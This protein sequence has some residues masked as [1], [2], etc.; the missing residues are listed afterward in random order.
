MVSLPHNETHTYSGVHAS[1]GFANFIYPLRLRNRL[2]LRK[3]RLL[4]LFELGDQPIMSS[5]P[6]RTKV[7]EGSQV[8]S[9]ES[10]PAH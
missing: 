8:L 4:A 6:A 10:K 5:Q 1:P 7:L 9:F 2:E 3:R